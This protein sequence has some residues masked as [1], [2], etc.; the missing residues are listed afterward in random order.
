MIND[1]FSCYAYQILMSIGINPSII[2]DTVNGLVKYYNVQNRTYHNCDHICHMLTEMDEAGWES[3]PL[4]FAILFHDVYYE[5]GV[6]SGYNEYNSFKIAK[7]VLDNCAIG[8]EIKLA[9]S[10]MIMA[11]ANFMNHGQFEIECQRIC[12]L[13]LS[14]LALQPYECFV[15]QQLNVLYE[16]GSKDLSKSAKFL[17]ELCAKRNNC[18][19]YTDYAKKNWLEPALDNIKMFTDEYV[20]RNY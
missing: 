16:Y 6:K 5:S 13:D 1:T 17:N 8:D 15:D 20:K 11:T 12:D 7:M 4:S 2:D 19:F 14:S 10:K 3:V 18:M 9:V